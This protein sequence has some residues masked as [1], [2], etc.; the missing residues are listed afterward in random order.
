VL[1]TLFSEKKIFLEK[2]IIE[3][4]FYVSQ[5]LFSIFIQVKFPN[6]ITYLDRTFKEEKSYIDFKM[7]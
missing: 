4:F 7:K 2:N 3:T 1:K 6:I 5:T